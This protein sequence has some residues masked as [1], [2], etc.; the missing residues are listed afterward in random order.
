MRF[1]STDEQPVTTGPLRDALVAA[2]SAYEVQLDD[3]ALTIV[4]AGARIAHVEINVPGDGLFDEERE[5]L[6]ESLSVAAGDDSA[7][8]NVVASLRAA[9]TIVAAQV[10]FGTGDTDSTL[11]ALDPLW[12]WLFR[13]RRGLLQ[14][15]G[16]GYYDARGLVL[17]VN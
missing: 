17:S 16:E 14:A 6:I 9:R 15:D 11:K 1:V 7:K 8:A 13:N 3:V 12:Q 4:H 10:L 2:G 5:E